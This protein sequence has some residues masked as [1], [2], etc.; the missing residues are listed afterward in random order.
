VSPQKLLEKGAVVVDFPG[1]RLLA[2]GGKS[3]SWMQWL[4]ERSPKGQVEAMPRTAPFGGG[5]HVK[6]RV[7]DG[8]EVPT[9][10]SSAQPQTA[11]AK[12]MFDPA[13]LAGAQ[14]LSGLHLRAGDSE[15]GPID[16][17]IR[18]ADAPVEGW[19]GLDVLRNVVLL[20]P[21]HEMAPIWLM[22]PR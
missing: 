4:D 2:L 14:H 11:Y 6:T 10:L 17:L 8:K 22:T 18:D 19:L 13:L 3:H 20:V 7:G 15:F 16:V 21:V 9:R 5:L 12:G 1:K